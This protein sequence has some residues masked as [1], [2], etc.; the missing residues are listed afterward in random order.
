MAWRFHDHIVRAAGL[1]PSGEN[2]GRVR[3]FRLFDLPEEILNAPDPLAAILERK[4]RTG[5]GAED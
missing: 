4:K 2:A 5:E 1:E 3:V